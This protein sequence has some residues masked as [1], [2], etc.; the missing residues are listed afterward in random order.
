MKIDKDKFPALFD[1]DIVICNFKSWLDKQAIDMFYDVLNTAKNNLYYTASTIMDHV[2]NSFEKLMPL[3]DGIPDACRGLLFNMGGRPH[4]FLYLLT[5]HEDRIMITGQV[6]AV[7]VNSQ[8]GDLIAGYFPKNSEKLEFHL[9][10]YVR[11]NSYV[12]QEAVKIILANELFINYAE[13]EKKQV[14]PS[15][16]IW[17]GPTCLYN[18]KTKYPITVVDSTW[19]TNLVVSGAFKVRGHFRLQPCG[20]GLKD[21]KLIWINDF[22]KE[23][24]T[25]KA[26]IE[27]L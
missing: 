20:Q 11:S 3:R 17:D 14:M 1:N 21:R 12:A 7:D 27:N 9:Y 26:K 2:S 5:N 6:Y 22:E 15:R 25:R 16:Q 10:E 4:T 19:F 8:Y 24:Y 18:N 13:V 23:G